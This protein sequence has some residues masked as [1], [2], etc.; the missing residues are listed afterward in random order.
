M[1]DQHR[2]SENL[3]RASGG[4]PPLPDALPGPIRYKE[5]TGNPHDHPLERLRQSCERHAKA[6]RGE[7]P[8]PDQ[9]ADEIAPDGQEVEDQ[10]GQV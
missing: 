2:T 3:Q 8:M 9:A 1:S 7:H 10:R 6:Q 4:D 5:P